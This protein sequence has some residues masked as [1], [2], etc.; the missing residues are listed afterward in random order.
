MNVLQEKLNFLLDKYAV[1]KE[2]ILSDDGKSVTVDGKTYPILPWRSERR[3]IELK[4]IVDS[5][6]V[7]AISH[8]KI[9]S[10]NPK[11]VSL[12]DVLMRELDTAEYIGSLKITEIFK[13]ENGP[14][15]AVI[16]MTDKKAVITLELSVNLKEGAALI[17]KHEIITDR[18]T[19]CDRA[20]DSQTPLYSVYV[21]GENTDEYTDVDFELYGLTAELVSVVRGAFDI[22]KNTELGEKN[23][24]IHARLLSLVEA[25]GLSAEKCENVIL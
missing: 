1:A 17:D 12:D 6:T 10:I 5:N 8:F 9:M 18:G 19:A 11:N 15:A 20:V 3:F 22:A 2:A 14:T 24:A 21:Y 16:C 7:G 13:A 23:L 4:K 25:A